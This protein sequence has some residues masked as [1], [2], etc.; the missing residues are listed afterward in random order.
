MEVWHT[1]AGT[2]IS[3]LSF[4]ESDLPAKKLEATPFGKGKPWN[5]MLTCPWIPVRSAGEEE[6]WRYQGSKTLCK[7]EKA[8]RVGTRSGDGKG[9]VERPMTILAGSFRTLF[10]LAEK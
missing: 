5:R 9:D 6:G 3:S 8:G 2:E 10:S 1:L 4:L 7:E